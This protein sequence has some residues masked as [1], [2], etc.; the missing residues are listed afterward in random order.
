MGNSKSDINV[1]MLFRQKLY[2]MRPYLLWVLQLDVAADISKNS[3]RQP[4]HTHAKNALSRC[5]LCFISTP[6]IP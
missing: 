5:Q 6:G 2:Q 3:H 4:D 1:F